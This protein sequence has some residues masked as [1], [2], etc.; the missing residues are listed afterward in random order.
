M[1]TLGESEEE[2]DK[3]GMVLSKDIKELE[4][5]GVDIGKG[6]K[7]TVITGDGDN[8]VLVAGKTPEDEE[9]DNQA[10]TQI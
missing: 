9:K 8:L 10:G 2:E 1:S 6:D 4:T 3:L 5:R 7:G